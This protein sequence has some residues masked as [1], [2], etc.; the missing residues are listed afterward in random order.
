MLLSHT[1]KNPVKELMSLPIKYDFLSFKHT[2]KK[3]LCAIEKL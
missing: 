2:I 1:D 3:L